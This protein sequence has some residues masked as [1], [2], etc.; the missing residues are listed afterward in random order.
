MM[1]RWLIIAA[2]SGVS[3]VA[4]VVGVDTEA[5]PAIDQP[6]EYDA[7]MLEIEREAIDKAFRD[8]SVRLFETWMKDNTGQP[9]RALNGM[10]QARSAY[11]QA[12]K[13]F[14]ERERKLKE[15]WP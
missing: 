1:A 2:L 8:Q 11:V 13:A 14:D 9:Q 15:R 4:L 5:Q 7:Q 10:R 3:I 6:T 12:M